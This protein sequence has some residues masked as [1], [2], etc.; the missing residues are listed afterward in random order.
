MVN[1]YTI[2]TSQ[3]DISSALVIIIKAIA[4]YTQKETDINQ[5]HLNDLCYC[6]EVISIFASANSDYIWNI[7]NS[8]KV[9]QIVTNLYRI[10]SLQDK[11]KYDQKNAQNLMKDKENMDRISDLLVN[12]IKLSLKKDNYSINLQTFNMILG[13]ALN[14]IAILETTDDCWKTKYLYIFFLNSSA[15][16]ILEPFIRSKRFSTE[17][18]GE[19]YKNNL[20]LPLLDAFEETS[21]F[22]SK[23]LACSYL[24]LIIAFLHRAFQQNYYFF[25]AF[26]KNHGY[27]L[28][29]SLLNNCSEK[30]L[31]TKIF[32]G[33]LQLSFFGNE[34][35]VKF[36][37]DLDRELPFQNPGFMFP[38]AN[39]GIIKIFTYISRI[40]I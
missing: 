21:A 8:L 23:I 28:I 16:L 20:F 37:I 4:T 40:S 17:L 5:L 36:I 10:C 7:F 29:S 31:Q 11:A 30:Q 19:V 33:I 15:I 24:D 18:L 25:E 32:D 22:K 38:P 9:I 1:S 14:P 12:I 35:L 3:L 34:N 27:S 2:Y 13:V 6:V 26:D 39:Q